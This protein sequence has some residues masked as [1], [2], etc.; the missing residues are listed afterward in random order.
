[1]VLSVFDLLNIALRPAGE[2]GN[3]GN[4]FLQLL[5]SRRVAKKA[6][7]K[8]YAQVLIGE[9]QLYNTIIF[10][11]TSSKKCKKNEKMNVEICFYISFFPADE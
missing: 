2:T 6:C 11:R 10:L 9:D 3:T 1:M 8:Q 5:L 7:Q 4:P